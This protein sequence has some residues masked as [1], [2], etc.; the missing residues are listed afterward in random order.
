MQV[1][2]LVCERVCVCVCMCVCECVETK[3]KREKEREHTL[4][5][6]REVSGLGFRV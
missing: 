1:G 5:R 2:T 6:E 4:G 3:R